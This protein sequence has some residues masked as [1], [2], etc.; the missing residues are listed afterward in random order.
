VAV[1]TC[2]DFWRR[3]YRSRE[4]PV[5]RLTEEHQK[6]LQEVCSDP[7]EPARHSRI[8]ARQVLQWA[9]ERLP[10]GDRMVFDMVYLQERP[11]KEA[12][13]L[14]GWSVVNVKVRAHRGRKKLKKLLEGLFSGEIDE[15]RQ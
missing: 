8:E 3:R 1:R 15:T 12:A 6:W 7:S 10:A 4:I 14:L 2:Y 5:S 13:R 9:L 11:V